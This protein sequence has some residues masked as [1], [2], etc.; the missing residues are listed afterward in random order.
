MTAG[1]VTTKMIDDGTHQEKYT[2]KGRHGGRTQICM[3]P[4]A[5][6][7]PL[8]TVGKYL[9]EPPY[10]DES[11]PP[12]TEIGSHWMTVRDKLK[13]SCATR[14]IGEM[15]TERKLR[16]M[17]AW[18][19]ARTITMVWAALLCVWWIGKF[20]H[21]VT[22]VGPPQREQSHEQRAGTGNRKKDG[23]LEWRQEDG[24]WTWGSDLHGQDSELMGVQ[25]GEE[26]GASEHIAPWTFHDAYCGIGGM[27]VG[28]RLAGGV[29]TGAFDACSRARPVYAQRMGTIPYGRWGTFDH[30]TWGSADVLFSSPPCEGKLSV[31]S[32]SQRQM[33]KQLELVKTHQYKV[34]II[35]MLLHF[36]RLEGGSLFHDFAQD[37]MA[38]G[39]E[40]GC[41]VLFAPDFA[42]SA[43]RRRLY[44]VGVKSSGT[45]LSYKDYSFPVGRSRH[46]P[47]YSILEPEFFRTNVRV[48]SRAYKEY[49]VERQRSSNCL[50]C[51]GEMEGAGPGRSV[52]SAKGLAS[53]Q[54]ATG[55]G[56]GWTSG[57]YRIGSY[58]SRLTVKEVAR[59]MQ[60]GDHVQLDEVESVARRHLGSTV[61]TGVARAL[62]VSAGRL[63][64]QRT[65]AAVE[66]PPPVQENARHSNLTR[67]GYGRARNQHAKKMAEWGQCDQAELTAASSRPWTK[68]RTRID[69]LTEHELQTLTQGVQVF[70]RRYWLYLQRLRGAEEV[71]R[72]VDEGVDPEVVLRAK[73]TI[74]KA[75]WL[76]RMRAGNEE[77]PINLLWWNW[78]GPV[79]KELMT[80][81]T[82]PL[83]RPPPQTF[84]DNYDTADVEKVWTEFARMKERRY[85]EGPLSKDEVYMTHPIAAVAKKGSEKIRIV[86]DMSVT[87]LNECMVAQRFILPQVEDV[88]QRCYEGCFMMTCDLQDGFYG[89]E[90]RGEDRK[91]L[92][93]KHPRTGKYYRYTRLAMGAACSPA[94]F[95]R[96]VAWAV[97]EAMQHPEFL[98]V[99]VVTNDSDPCMPRVYGTDKTGAPVATMDWFV[100]D[101]CIIA[102]TANR[103]L[104]AYKRLVWVLESRLGWR[105][106]QRK[107]E[108]PAQR[109]VFWGLELD[110]VGRDVGGPCT[111]LSDDRREEC[112][113]L[114][115]EFTKQY[116][117]QKKAPRRDMASLV[118]KLSFAANAVPAGRCFLVRLYDAIHETRGEKT[119]D[120]I[121]YDRWVKVTGAAGLDL[122]WWEQCL[123][124]AECVRRWS[125]QTFALSRCW[126]DASN[127]GF[128]E[129][130][131]VKET[132]DYPQMVF[133]H[134]VWPDAVAAFSSNWHELATIVHSIKSREG[135]LRGSSVHYMT[136]N[137]TAVKAVNTG[138]VTSEQLMRLSRELKLVQARSDIHIEAIHLP[139]TMMQM[140]GTDQASRACPFE[141]MY[142][143]NSGHHDTFAPLEWPIF[144]L[145]GP[146]VEVLALLYPEGM[147]NTGLHAEDW[148]GAVELAGK[149]TYMH[150]RPCHVAPALG[151]LLEAQLREGGSTS[152]TV[153]APMVGLRGWRKYLKHFRRREVHKVWV[154]GLGEVKHWLLRYEGGDG[155]LPRGREAQEEEN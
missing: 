26:E 149:D 127:Y 80:G 137:S 25:L 97:R 139:G 87:L 47:L 102:P 23:R 82:I 75:L 30:T 14:Q 105:I 103:C 132:G 131:A 135:E 136:D 72:L 57:L 51:C 119:G 109:L 45:Q 63:L 112:L 69:E 19:L 38:L 44:M 78:S 74:T 146:I 15:D 120:A 92:G 138:T 118:G 154:P 54:T 18:T 96:L 49:E 68:A 111:R 88:A 36:K 11:E 110:S 151:A 55:A 83:R 35:E 9:R 22:S 24:F 10:R 122:R 130:L 52:Y 148:Y 107:T 89:V 33:W 121:D 58:V 1:P 59:L 125:T 39:Y 86:I 144:E 108:G 37:F 106:C 76:E 41:K 32:N 114:L 56:P 28:A 147:T 140:Q 99:N 81:Y 12:D 116:L 46:H 7:S 27:S 31:T 29:C 90:V 91:Y 128:A 2:R 100:D 150:L 4:Q 40:V 115:R 66:T 85:M 133:S 113:N 3:P 126:S 142:S 60:I 141:G 61:P 155:L 104:A 94:A 62:A 64:Q 145:N 34:V 71:Q 123:E 95:S 20:R 17:D 13:K 79:P 21:E 5:Q 124:E 143:G 73:Q 6:K 129:C 16:R 134:G 98:P 77:G 53:A 42:S 153:V 84:P 65:A 67:E 93:L 152:F 8:A 43:A 48:S 117:W 101:G 50:T 70:H